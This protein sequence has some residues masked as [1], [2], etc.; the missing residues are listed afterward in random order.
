MKHQLNA[1]Y[2]SIELRPLVFDDIEK[3]R[4]WRNDA[5]ATRFLRPI[6]HVTKEMQEEWFEK[7]LVDDDIITFSIVETDALNRMIGSVS[8]YNFRGKRAEIG[9]IQ[10]GDPE[11]HGRGI[12]KKALVMAIKIGFNL[13]DLEII[14]GAVHQE[15]VSAH[16][17]D[18]SVGFK[19][20]GTKESVVGGKEDIIEID[21][22]QAKKA[23]LYFDRI[24]VFKNE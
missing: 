8:I 22:E 15:N 20:V 2:E 6:G 3:L 9:K 5:I 19:I 10:I 16:K 7:Y 21:I 24:V 12:G 13:L 17:N 18:M 14:D 4:I 1:K 23:N 11:A